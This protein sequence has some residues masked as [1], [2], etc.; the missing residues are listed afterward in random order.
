MFPTWALPQCHPMAR[1]DTRSNLLTSVS[2][3]GPH[4]PTFQILLFSG[5]VPDAL[6]GLRLHGGW[7]PQLSRPAPT[8][9]YYY[10][11]ICRPELKKV[12]TRKSGLRMLDHQYPLWPPINKQHRIVRR[13]KEW[14]FSECS[15]SLIFPDSLLSFPDLF[16]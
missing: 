13:M 4:V 11:L 1:E 5:P 12:M 7:P 14:I 16:H 9:V 6:S 3:I 10:N 8:L 15:E 2:N